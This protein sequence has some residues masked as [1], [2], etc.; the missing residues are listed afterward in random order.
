MISFDLF[1]K[2]VFPEV[3]NIRIPYQGSKNKIALQLFE[4]MLE[5][6]PN[7]KYF[8]FPVDK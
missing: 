7:A 1:G 2:P 6:K 8:L 5:I 3:K 4:K